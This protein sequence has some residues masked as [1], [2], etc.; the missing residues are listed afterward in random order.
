MDKSLF[1]KF[2]IGTYCLGK[3]ARDEQHV[4][5]LAECGMDIL[6]GVNYD[7]P[8]LDL[9]EKYGVHV[10]PNGVLPGWFGGD[11]KNAGM[12]ERTN[13]IESY[14]RGI[15]AFSDH[16]AIIGL[17]IGDEPSSLDF[18][19]Y[20][21]VV[22]ILSECFPDKLLYLNIYPSYGMLKDAS[23]EQAKREL[24]TDTYRD[25]LTSYCENVPLPYLSIDHYPFSLSSSG[26]DRF[27]SDLADAAEICRAYSRPLMTVLEV[28]SK[29]PE[30]FIS[31]DELRLQ[32]YCALAYGSR[33]VSW[34]CY[35][36][37][38]WQNNALDRDGNKTEQYEK[39]KEVNGE[40][41][42]F[43][44]EY[45]KYTRLS[46]VRLN[47]GES[48][49]IAPFGKI[50][51]DAPVLVGSF[52]DESG[53]PAILVA[54]LEYKD[55]FNLRFTYSASRPL[56]LRTTQDAPQRLRANDSEETA[57]FSRGALFVFCE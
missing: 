30:R 7:K 43:T 34:A 51:A 13:S 42:R 46:T 18:P 45:E 11:G 16:P 12:L 9:L 39:L 28:N 55:G 3:N 38:W 14:I 47:V 1:Q 22:D 56:M 20:G 25:Y 5:E 49:S 29:E 54:P 32:A 37:G 57:I 31:A 21:K 10:V 17:D 33:V 15:E 27:L 41:K 2:Y 35:S 36:P 23:D 50:S 4:K 6:F 48:I 40:L 53:S 8:L 19:Y 52:E 44:R 24:G 26:I